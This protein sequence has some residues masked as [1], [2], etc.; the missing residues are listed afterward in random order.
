MVGLDHGY[1]GNTAT[2]IDVSPWA[3]ERYNIEPD[4]VTMGKPT[5][6]G[7]PLAVV[8]TTRAIAAAFNNGMGYFNTLN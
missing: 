7:Q 1:H 5:G 3:F 4:V 6:N 2:L 8:A